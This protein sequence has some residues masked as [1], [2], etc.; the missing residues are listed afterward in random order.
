MANFSSKY[1]LTALA[2]ALSFV[3]PAVHA[4]ELTGQIGPASQ[5]ENSLTE[6]YYSFTGD[7]QAVLPAGTS[8]LYYGKGVFSS[9]ASDQTIEN[10]SDNLGIVSKGGTF[11]LANGHNQNI[12]LA[13]T[14]S[15]SSESGR[16]FWV[17]G[18]PTDN[19]SSAVT[20]RIT[21]E[22][23]EI[24]A[25]V[26]N[27]ALRYGFGW[28]GASGVYEGGV[29]YNSQ[30][31][32]IFG[33]SEADPG[34]SIGKIAIEST[35]APSPYG[36]SN[37]GPAIV[38]RGPNSDQ[39]GIQKIFM[40]IGQIGE[41]NQRFSVGVLDVYGSEQYIRSIGEIYATSFGI[42][43]GDWTST[44][45]GGPQRVK[46]VGSIDVDN[47]SAPS[48][49]VMGIYNWS[50]NGATVNGKRHI[51]S[52]YIG[53][54]RSIVASGSSTLGVFGIF[55]RG[56]EQIIEAEPEVAD[57]AV[58]ISATNTTSGKPAYSVYINPYMQGDAFAEASTKT[59]LKGNFAIKKGDIVVANSN[60]TNPDKT[61]SNSVLQLLGNSRDTANTMSLD[62]GTGI[63][64]MKGGKDDEWG[65]LTTALILGDDRESGDRGYNISLGKGSYINDQGIF[66]GKGVI[67]AHYSAASVATNGIDSGGVLLKNVQTTLAGNKSHLDVVVPGAENLAY[68]D[69]MPVLK[70]AVNNIFVDKGIDNIFSTSEWVD[71]LTEHKTAGWVT[72]GTVSIPE[73]II[74]PAVS[75]TWYFADPEIVGNPNNIRDSLATAALQLKISN[76]SGSTGTADDSSGDVSSHYSVFNADGKLVAT[77]AS[78]RTVSLAADSVR[79]SATLPDGS[80]VTVTPSTDAQGMT[81][82]VS[83][84]GTTV[85]AINEE[86]KLVD[87][88]G[89]EIEVSVMTNDAKA[90]YA[91]E[92]DLGYEVIEHPE[93]PPAS[94]ST[95]DSVDSA[96]MT[97]YFL[98]RQENETLYQ[99]M[100]EVRDRA[101]ME[102]AWVRILNGRNRYDRKGGYFRNDYTGIQ[103]GID[104]TDRE[105]DGKWTWGGALTYT[106]GDSKLSNGGTAD[107][108][109]GSLS[110]YGTRKYENGGYLDLILK[111]SRMN[112]DFTAI[113]DQFRYVTRGDYHTNAWQASAEYGRKFYLNEKKEWYLDPQIQLTVGH[114]NGV[115]Y[116]T[117]NDLNIKIRGTDS[118]IGRIGISLAREWKEGSSF[119]K[120]DGL[121]EFT[122]RYKADYSLD[123]G[124]W[125]RSEIS[126]KD[127]WGEIVAGGSYNLSKDTF[128]FLQVKR[129]FA[130]DIQTD[131]RLDVGLRYQF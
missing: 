96:N 125:N 102:G 112:N 78:G 92:G 58:S 45:D 17:N 3:F 88:N 25:N 77:S 131:Y 109:I 12:N 97:N 8:T 116:R 71:E 6:S 51:G 53:V 100:G 36:A 38:N 1:R 101:D 50:D 29:I 99:R 57:S 43:G 15:I 31:I 121:R 111:A 11:F 76:R 67:S 18:N 28:N 110:V 55:N 2:A 42:A 95:M 118:V 68:E 103:L 4:N 69:V 80:E 33:H 39:I 52:Q 106:R 79:L 104:R 123:N 82:L 86:G 26:G 83:G 49:L 60:S 20:Q 24:K 34:G 126:M 64:I 91:W 46:Y 84:D 89:N 70:S 40:P 35:A 27:Y 85:L 120:L 75:T 129:S 37:R 65:T 93:E 130:A 113:S 30:G 23:A 117:D 66:Q 73:G 94:T 122:A 16:I 124:A 128:G 127:T 72:A 47:T 90:L 62:D 32:Q 56:G 63:R 59:T 98:W 81:S 21:G 74:T 9:A 10:K 119:I 61:A 48:P 114:I 54:G 5:K 41:K 14:K 108:W 105:N 19:E 44:S 22:I 7:V 87:E 13:K 115:N 107:N